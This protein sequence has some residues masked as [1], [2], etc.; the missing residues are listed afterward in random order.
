MNAPEVG[1]VYITWANL[2]EWVCKLRDIYKS[3]TF[4]LVL[5]VSR[6]GIIPGFAVAN[7]LQK[8]YL[9]VDA[10][11]ERWEFV[12]GQNVLLVDDIWDTGLT[13]RT[14]KDK[15]EKAGAASVEMVYMIQKNIPELKN[16]WYTFPW[17]C[18]Q[19]TMG[20]REQ[21]VVS[22]LRSIGE[23]PN[24]DGL[25]DTPKRVAR[26]YDELFQGYSQDPKNLLSTTFECSDYDEMIILKDINFTSWCEHHMQMFSGHAHV[27]YIPSDRVVGL[28]KLARLVE[29]FAHRLQ[30]QERM[31]VQIGKTIEEVLKPKGVGVVVKASHM[32]MKCRGVKNQDSEM[33]TS[34]LGGDFR[35]DPRTRDEFMA[36]LKG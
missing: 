17:E 32:C 27:A 9:T 7:A 20:G 34:Y 30:I 11:S 36:L 3:R 4:D 21:A 6:G 33:I 18:E 28:S 14:V 12:K 25:K 16:T 31:T 22:L 13:L 1:L 10:F 26:M 15:I 23:D 5:G 8:S 2:D 29:C 35:T 19:D 24:R